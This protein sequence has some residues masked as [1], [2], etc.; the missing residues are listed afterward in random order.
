MRKQ[1]LILGKTKSTAKMALAN[2]VQTEEMGF[3][4]NCYSPNALRTS[5]YDL[6]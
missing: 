3:L 6:E 4:K 1:K 5:K 2:Q